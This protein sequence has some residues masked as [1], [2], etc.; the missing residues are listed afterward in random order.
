MLLRTRLLEFSRPR[1]VLEGS[2]IASELCRTQNQ[3]PTFLNFPSCTKDTER[4]GKT[5][6]EKVRARWNPKTF[7]GSYLKSPHRPFGATPSLPSLGA[8]DPTIPLEPEPQD[9]TAKSRPGVE[10]PDLPSPPSPLRRPRPQQVQAPPRPTPG[11]RCAF[12]P[13]CR[14]Q[15]QSPNFGAGIGDRTRAWIRSRGSAPGAVAQVGRREQRIWVLGEVPQRG[16]AAGKGAAAGP[17]ESP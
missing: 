12:F 15:R 17:P 6:P 5:G 13:E 2:H 1:G 3:T 9:A 14:L 4:M 16:N 7:G 11:A 8:R 10:R